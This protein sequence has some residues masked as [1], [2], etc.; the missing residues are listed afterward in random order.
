[1]GDSSDERSERSEPLLPPHMPPPEPPHMPLFLAALS[2]LCADM[3]CAARVGPLSSFALVV[4][5]SGP[6]LKKPSPKRAVSSNPRESSATS[7]ADRWLMFELNPNPRRAM[8][9]IANA[10][11]LADL[12]DAAASC[13]RPAADAS[14]GSPLSGW[15][16]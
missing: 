13:A 11:V 4:E 16:K 8:S 15:G 1:M 2:W 3:Y 12:F 9:F 6:M 10:W 5:S 7:E 14:T